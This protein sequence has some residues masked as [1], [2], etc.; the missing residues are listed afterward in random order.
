MGFWRPE[1][2][3]RADCASIQERLLANLGLALPARPVL[4]MKFH[5]GHRS[6]D[7]LFLGLQ[8]KYR[9]P[10]EDFLCLGEGSVSH[11][12]FDSRQQVERARRSLDECADTVHL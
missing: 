4:L 10:T 1:H 3:V 12:K 9:I 8:F 7:R 11:G 2:L 6:F 5:K